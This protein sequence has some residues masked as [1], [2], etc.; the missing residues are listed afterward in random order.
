MRPAGLLLGYLASSALAELW[1]QSSAVL[2]QFSPAATLSRVSQHEADVENMQV[3]PEER[4]GAIV[5]RS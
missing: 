4:D 3:E 1:V 5:M 2:T